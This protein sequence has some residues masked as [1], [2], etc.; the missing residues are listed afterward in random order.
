MLSSYLKR[1]NLFF[2]KIYA[3]SQR[4]HHAS[5]P[6]QLN[7]IGFNETIIDEKHKL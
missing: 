7:E 6:D 1:R 3:K 2:K 5:I 4:S